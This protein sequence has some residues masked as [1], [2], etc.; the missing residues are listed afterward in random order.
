LIFDQ[1][2][3]CQAKYPAFEL[4]GY[5]PKTVSG[6]SLHFREKMFEPRKK[7]LWLLDGKVGMGKR[8]DE[9]SQITKILLKQ[10][11]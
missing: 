9:I 5:P 10:Q 1:K 6:A 8:V 11:K 4:A 7:L 3:S 2:Y